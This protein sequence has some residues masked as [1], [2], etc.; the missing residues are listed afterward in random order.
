M[1]GGAV[2][3]TGIVG[4]AS[5]SAASLPY[6]PLYGSPLVF[7]PNIFLSAYSPDRGQALWAKEIPTILGGSLFGMALDSKTRVVMSGVYSGSMQADDHMLVTG[8]PEQPNVVD[9]FVASFSEPSPS[10]PPIIG[11]ATD[12]S[13]ASINTVPSTIYAEATSSAGAVVFFMPPT[14]IDNG[15]SPDGGPGVARPARPWS[16][17][18]L[19]TRRS[20][21]G[22]RR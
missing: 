21:S 20:P 6:F 18:P 16:A 10:S 9:S 13:G 11:A 2:D 7:A 5:G 14:A 3:F 12:P 22:R 4:P 15:D 1:T 19:R 17:R 8:V